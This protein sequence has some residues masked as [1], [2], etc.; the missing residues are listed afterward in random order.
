MEWITRGDVE[1][2]KVSVLE[3]LNELDDKFKQTI[4]YLE[5]SLSQL[6]DSNNY[7]ARKDAVRDCMSAKESLLK[8]LSEKDD[9]KM[10][11]I[12]YLHQENVVQ[13]QFLKMETQYGANY[14][15]C[16]QMLGMGNHKHQI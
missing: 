6:K 3:I 4:E 14:I 13:E 8:V 9:K 12:H 7:R 1:I 15:K 10:Q 16:I 11:L 2:D 5:R